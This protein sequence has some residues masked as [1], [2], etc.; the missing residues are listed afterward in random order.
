MYQYE[1]VYLQ[2]VIL[3]KLHNLIKLFCD[4]D[5]IFLL[6]FFIKIEIRYILYII[7]HC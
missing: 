2:Y 4:N 1:F 6:L 3:Y 5:N 7:Y